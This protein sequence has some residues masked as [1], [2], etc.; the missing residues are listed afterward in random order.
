MGWRN[1]HTGTYQGSEKMGPCTHRIGTGGL[2]SAQH[3]AVG[4]PTNDATGNHQDL[5]WYRSPPDPKPAMDAI[6][7]LL[8]FNAHREPERLAL[9]YRKMRMNAFAFLRGSCHLFYARWHQAM[10][11][12][13]SPLAWICGDLH[14][15]NFGSYKGDNR[16]VYFD[17]NDF[18][19]AALAPASWD[20]LHMLTGIRISASDQNKE[21]RECER[22]CAAFLQGYAEALGKGKAYWVERDTASGAVLTLLQDLR[23]RQRPDFLDARTLRKG[24]QR[25]LRLDGKKALEATPS[26]RATVTAFMASFARTQADPGFY[27][28]LDIAR[29][30]A[31]TGSLGLERY[32]IL[33]RGKGLLDGNYLLD[34]KYAAPS[35]LTPYLSA[36]Q[37]D[38]PTQADRIVTL[39]QRLQAMPMAFLHAE[40]M[41]NAAYV[42]RGLQ[43]SEDRL[44]MA[45]LAQTPD[46]WVELVGSLGR[47][48]AWA[49]LRGAG[50]QGSANADALV[51][52]GQSNAWRPRLLDASRA[53]A[54]Q[55]QADAAAFNAA[56]DLGAFGGNVA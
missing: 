35:S 16:Q 10:P 1:Q 45:R 34:L 37:P 54:Q 42:L 31:G 17:I 18:D 15:E 55:V 43:P 30:I 32:V 2:Q 24:K 51:D 38:W 6:H 21:S 47:M 13:A 44:D 46:Q 56:Y 26:Q 27:D 49:H 48:T 33:V 11:A 28:V 50:R 36:P 40:R 20:L 4:P 23:E 3:S 14:W 9:K 22:M 12:D 7:Q 53:C 19:E 41:D 8:T 25:A 52:Y 39:Q 29:R 5:Q